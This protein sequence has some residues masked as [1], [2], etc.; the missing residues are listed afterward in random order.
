MVAEWDGVERS[1]EMYFRVGE[2]CFFTYNADEVFSQESVRLDNDM[3][4]M[5]K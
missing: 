5:L 3:C 4:H 1:D 2:S